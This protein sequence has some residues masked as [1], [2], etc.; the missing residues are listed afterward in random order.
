MYSGI[1]TLRRLCATLTVSAITTVSA[2]TFEAK[3]DVLLAIDL[4]RSAIVERLV[5]RWEGQFA[6][7]QRQDLSKRLLS[8][9]AD[10]LAAVRLTDSFDSMLATLAVSEQRSAN[11]AVLSAASAGERSKAL[12][13]SL[14][15]QAYTPVV[16]CRIWDTRTEYG[17][18]GPIAAGTFKTFDTS[19]PGLN[20]GSQGGSPSLDCGIPAG[21]TA[22]V[23]MLGTVLPAAQGFLTLFPTGGSNPFP[24]AVNQTYQANLVTTTETI[25]TTQ[26]AANN[27]V[28]VYSTVTANVAA[29]VV[30]YLMPPSRTGNGLRVIQTNDVSRPDAPIMISGSTSNTASGAGAT[31]TGGGYT[32]NLCNNPVTNNLDYTCANSATNAFAMVGGGYSNAASGFSST[33]IG[34]QGNIA[35]NNN[36]TIVGGTYNQATGASTSVVGGS[37]NIASGNYATVNGGQQN[38][39]TGGW[40][41]VSGGNFNT[42]G[43]DY[44]WAGGRR[45][46]TQSDNTLTATKH[47][48]AFVWADNYAPATDF[49]STAVNQF[50]AR[51]TGGFRFVT[52]VSP[53]AGAELMAGSGSWTSLS[54]RDSKTAFSAVNVRAMLNKVLAM[55]ITTW[56][57]KAQDKSI[58]H[59]GPIAQDFKKLFNVGETEKG[60]SAVD[61]DGVAFAAIQGLNQKLMDVIKAKDAELA[62]VNA[63]LTAIKKKLGL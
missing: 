22:V 42:S 30:G 54:D 36:A 37:T 20:F 19:R 52:G 50:S 43:G 29:D 26:A 45:A 28:S 8:L 13:D 35:S 23:V 49:Y 21:V 57:Y 47:H 58:R 25:A 41:T 62:K 5:A 60:I 27:K 40:S 59:I 34:G 44:S 4:N 55:P 56:Q 24:F 48:G 6:P 9:R 2:G 3:P 14:I 39:A 17:G 1:F 10:E 11:S 53:F 15:D 51:A 63:D 61:S 46:F 31:V 7:S 12:G 32:G 18:T 33:I 16:P 38:K